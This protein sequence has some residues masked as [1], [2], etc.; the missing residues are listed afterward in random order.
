MKKDAAKVNNHV[1][2]PGV[3]ESRFELTYKNTEYRTTVLSKHIT[4]RLREAFDDKYKYAG[5]WELLFSTYEHGRSYQMMLKSVERRTWPF[6]LVCETADGDLLGAFF[7]DRLEIRRH[8]Y[9]K[10]STFLFCTGMNRQ[11]EKMAPDDVMIFHTTSNNN[12]NILC[13]P[14]FLAFG[15]SDGQFGLLINRSLQDGETHSVTTFENDPLA[16]KE[17]FE[18]SHLEIWSIL[19]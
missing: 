2:L 4:L 5:R 7:E 18:I 13:T 10:C 19:V 17:R 3:A 15:C 8:A 1:S 9:G 11:K 6:V 12:I 14:D 16:S